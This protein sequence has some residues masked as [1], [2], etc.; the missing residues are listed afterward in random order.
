MELKILTT[1]LESGVPV[2]A[3]ASAAFRPDLETENQ[4]VNVH[5]DIRYQ[6]FQGFGGTFTE[7]ACYCMHEAG[8][9]VQRQILEAYFGPAGLKYTH[10]R[11]HLDSADASLD[12]YSAMNDPNDPEM[13]TFSL[14]RDEKYIL[15]VVKDA[16]SPTGGVS[17]RSVG[18][19]RTPSGF[20]RRIFGLVRKYAGFTRIIFGQPRKL[21]GD[22][23]KSAG[24]TRMASGHGPHLS[25]GVR[26]DSAEGR[27]LS[28]PG[29]FATEGGRK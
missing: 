13:R 3:E 16:I 4:V 28:G 6:A 7:A 12:N 24:S 23:R 15:P 10:A 14:S 20:V 19:G 21:P 17:T 18:R 27:R 5:P 25:G 2:Q 1:T 8:E 26:R 9:D 29:R 22:V 11:L